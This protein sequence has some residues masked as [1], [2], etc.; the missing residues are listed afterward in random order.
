MVNTLFGNDPA[1]FAAAA[2]IAVIVGIAR[3]IIMLKRDVKR[4]FHRGNFK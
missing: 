2:A 3:F 4:R 1:T